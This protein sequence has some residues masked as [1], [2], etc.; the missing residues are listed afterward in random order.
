MTPTNRSPQ[1]LHHAATRFD[2]GVYFEANGHG[3]VLFSAAAIKAINTYEPQSPAQQSAVETLQA[4]TELINQTVGDAISDMLL[5]EVIL[6]HKHWGMQEWLGM[7]FS[8]LFSSAWRTHHPS[9]PTLI[10]R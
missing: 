7:S 5:V 6:A 8:S 2:V 9:R 1:H 4:L 10:P 3:T